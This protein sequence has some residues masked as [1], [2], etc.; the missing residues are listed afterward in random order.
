VMYTDKHRRYERGEDQR[1]KNP[2]QRLRPNR[3]ERDAGRDRYDKTPS[4][5]S[6]KFAEHRKRSLIVTPNSYSPDRPI[7]TLSIIGKIWI[8]GELIRDANLSRI[9]TR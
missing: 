2:A 3:Y 8:R 6:E 7:R 5:Y 9:T 1:K 4:W